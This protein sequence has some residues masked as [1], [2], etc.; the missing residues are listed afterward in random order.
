M[1]LQ[2]GRRHVMERIALFEQVPDGPL[3]EGGDL[4]SNRK[5]QQVVVGEVEIQ[6]KR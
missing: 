1:R 2:S 3:A 6:M 4:P 5:E